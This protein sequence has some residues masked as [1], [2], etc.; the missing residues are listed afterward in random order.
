MRS[1]RNQLAF[2]LMDWRPLIIFW[3]VLIVVNIVQVLDLLYWS[4]KTGSTI[5]SVFMPNYGA[6][7]VFVLVSGILSATITFPLLMS[8]GYTRKQFYLTTIVSGPIFCAVMAIIQ[9]TIVYCGRGIL[10]ALGYHLETPIWSVASVGYL[11][12]AIYCMIFYL[13]FLIGSVFYLY[14]TLPGILVI[15][16]YIAVLSYTPVDNKFDFMDYFSTSLEYNNH[17]YIHYTWIISAIVAVA[18]WLLYRRSAVRT[19]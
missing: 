19:Y 4:S 18:G 17:T 15:A 10:N 16:A 3:A 8:V 13:S 9:C 14:G 7:S 2:Q 1:F 6:A 5:Y 12:L 11:Q